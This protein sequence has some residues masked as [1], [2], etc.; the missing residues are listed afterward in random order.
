MTVDLN[1]LCRFFNVIS[2]QFIFVLWMGHTLLFLCVHCNSLCNSGHFEYGNVATL[3][4]IL[5]PFPRVC[6]FAF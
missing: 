3:N 2:S 6:C 5:C 4:I 1:S